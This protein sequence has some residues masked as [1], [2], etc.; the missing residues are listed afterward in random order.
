MIK[1]G[2]SRS[3]PIFEFSL[4][5][6]LL[7][8]KISYTQNLK[9]MLLRI[10]TL[11]I[12][13]I[14]TFHQSNSEQ[15]IKA[16]SYIISQKALD[17]A[18]E[19]YAD[20][21]LQAVRRAEQEPMDDIIERHSCDKSYYIYASRAVKHFTVNSLKVNIVSDGI[22]IN[23]N[24][25]VIFYV[26]MRIDWAKRVGFC[27]RRNICDGQATITANLQLS[28]KFT[29]TWT[30]GSLN[31]TGIPTLTSENLQ[32]HGCSP[33]A[34]MNVFFNAKQYIHD[35][36]A[37]GI[38]EKINK[39]SE[40]LYRQTLF[41]PYS[42]ILF[43]YQLSTVVFSPGSS[44]LVTASCMIQANRTN[45]D[46]SVTMMTYNDPDDND[47][48]MQPPTTWDLSLNNS[49]YQL[50]GIRVS[51]TLL[52]GFIWAAQTVGAFNTS[53]TTPFLD[54]N[55]KF[56][57]EFTPPMTGVNSQGHLLVSISSGRTY[58]TCSPV[59]EYRENCS[60]ILDIS[61][62]DLS[63]R[64]RVYATPKDV[65]VII[66]ILDFNVSDS[67]VQVNWP[68]LPIPPGFLGSI[69]SLAL[70]HM[71]PSANDYLRENPLMM[72]P[73][74]ASLIPNPSLTLVNQLG[75]CNGGHGYLDF[76]S[77]CSIVDVHNQW[78]PCTFQRDVG[79]KQYGDVRDMGEMKQG[80]VIRK[81]LGDLGETK[82]MQMRDRDVKESPVKEIYVVEY[83]G[84]CV[85][86]KHVMATI[87]NVSQACTVDPD[88]GLY[89]VNFNGNDYQAGLYCNDS[90]SIS[91]CQIV[92][93]P[94]K[95][96]ECQGSISL[97]SSLIILSEPGEGVVASYL[98]TE[99]CDVG[100]NMM[101]T[102]LP[103][104][105][106]SD[107][108]G[109]AG[110]NDIEAKIMSKTQLEISLVNSSLP[111][112]SVNEESTRAEPAH[113]MLY[114]NSCGNLS[115]ISIQWFNERYM[116]VQEDS[117]FSLIFVQQPLPRKDKHLNKPLIISLCIFLPLIVV[118]IVIVSVK[119][120]RVITL[121]KGRI[122]KIKSL[123]AKPVRDGVNNFFNDVRDSISEK[124][125]KFSSWLK[126]SIQDMMRTS[127]YKDR[128]GIETSSLIFTLMVTFA[129]MSLWLRYDPFTDYISSVLDELKISKDLIC[130]TDRGYEILRNWLF[131]T[132]YGISA[133]V[134]ISTALIIVSFFFKA[135][136]F[137]I[138]CLFLQ[139]IGG[140]LLLHGP[141]MTFKYK[142]MISFASCTF[143]Q[144]NISDISLQTNSTAP[145]FIVDF[146]E[147]KI[148]MSFT[149]LGIA[150]L[151]NWN[152]FW[153]QGF[154][155]GAVNACLYFWVI[156]DYMAISESI[157]VIVG[158]ITPIIIAVPLSSIVAIVFLYQGFNVDKAWLIVWLIWWLASLMVILVV[159]LTSRQY[160]K[161]LKSSGGLKNGLEIREI[162]LAKHMKYRP[163]RNTT[164]SWLI[165]I[166]YILTQV[167][168]FAY[169]LYRE[170]N[171][172]VT[173][174]G[175][176]AG[177]WIL[178]LGQ[179]FSLLLLIFHDP[180][181]K[182]VEWSSSSVPINVSIAP[183]NNSVVPLEGES[184]EDDPNED[185]PNEASPLLSKGTSINSPEKPEKD[186]KET[187]DEGIR[188]FLY[189]VGT[190]CFVVSIFM[191]LHDYI[192]NPVIEEILDMLRDG[193]ETLEWPA[194]GTALD[195]VI[196]TYTEARWNQ[197]YSNFVSLVFLCLVVF[198]N[199]TGKYKSFSKIL[200]YLSI[201][202]LFVGL[203]LVASPNYLDDMDIDQ[204]LPNCAPKFNQ[205]IP[206][207][208]KTSLGLMC[209]MIFSAK[210]CVL[211]FTFPP[212][213]AR[214]SNML[215]LHISSHISSHA[216]GSAD[217][218]DS[219]SHAEGSADVVDSRDNQR[220]KENSLLW[221]WM[222]AP[223]F[224]SLMTILPITFVTQTIGDSIILSI[225]AVFWISPILVSVIVCILRKKFGFNSAKFS[226]ASVLIWSTC[227]I[228][229]IVALILY[230]AYLYHLLHY[231][232][233]MLWKVD[234]WA[235]LIAEFAI[236][237]VVPSDFIESCIDL[238]QEMS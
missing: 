29:I 10:Y 219:R 203:L 41:N 117:G 8:H 49:L 81:N 200:G 135:R 59:G 134:L 237:L 177:Y 103:N 27:F 66:E 122:E 167:S 185:D 114:P 227:Y 139:L 230:S 231:I 179:A 222:S 93:E 162:S 127:L 28:I 3:P 82:A 6:H 206:K 174:L 178:P 30:S 90:C 42:G 226:I 45:P 125:G 55:V 190:I 155:G 145:K 123:D 147:P 192:Y 152:L 176:A 182:D 146:L 148:Q 64:G 116:P 111:T 126:R 137:I 37:G 208:I 197:L 52:G 22:L 171:L 217:I 108:V 2:I 144:V 4:C 238:C 118:S 158:V 121:I 112:S 161:G 124:V 17:D 96:G 169:S 216:E 86:E 7:T 131:F 73:L 205:V 40:D 220:R 175:F 57:S 168:V 76:G 79:A 119:R 187:P 181:I 140:F 109:E 228:G 26:P 151:T 223:F 113:I 130:E 94:M 183:I 102:L 188:N 159:V 193:D 51:S 141:P 160:I 221:M 170:D 68:P 47:A 132:K 44:V 19:R 138:V 115:H 229:P 189:I 105:G 54:A 67:N 225:L 129:A 16:I 74:V 80:D 154:L 60:E 33:P 69:E 15:T 32:I 61:F 191:T 207:T 180:E 214:S 92:S 196:Q 58:L 195:P 133:L 85:M 95:L 156:S 99:D 210:V 11:T 101:F 36:M 70:K 75:C 56:V 233:E 218:I 53:Y 23:T 199:F 120:K 165:F 166:F 24:I 31:I 18:P 215:L 184:D 136:N 5:Q 100:R 149:A 88:Y 65:G 97:Q 142:E 9:S 34:W 83:D 202:G 14:L 25:D 21:V 89:V 107:I 91:S 198:L 71:L 232:T 153:L 194:N 12:L 77:Y 186:H 13:I 224:G 20:F 39:F 173:N 204:Y 213:L 78:K 38:V 106:D 211:V 87:V 128:F 48:N 150:S 143:A 212:A 46:G 234:F 164:G 50:Q 62:H 157:Y 1:K 63:G 110:D 35:Q 209:A 201:L 43:R 104:I 235:V 172:T 84:D 236:S 98:N 72:P 163:R